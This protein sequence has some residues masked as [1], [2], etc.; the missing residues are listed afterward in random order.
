VATA[1]RSM[2]MQA[3]SLKDSVATAIAA[4]AFL[5]EWVAAC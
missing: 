1:I 3:R 5:L 2:T 4:G